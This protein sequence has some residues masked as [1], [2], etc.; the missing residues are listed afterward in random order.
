MEFPF[1]ND[2][3]DSQREAVVYT[4]G[5]SLV[6]AGAGSGKTRV[7]TYKVAW[8]LHQGMHPASILALTF[9]NKAAREMKTRIGQMVG[10]D[11]ARY[12]WMGTFHSLFARILR[13][14]AERIGYTHHFT[15]YDTADSKSLVKAI[16]K[17]MQLDD[18]VYKPGVVLGRISSAKNSLVTPQAYAADSG[19]QQSDRLAKVPMM[20]EIYTTYCAR[21]KQADAMDFDD[22]LLQTNL[23]F[24]DHPDV[25]QKYQS[26]F[27]YILVDEYQD[28]NFAQYLIVKKLAER[29]E[30]ICVVGD[31]AQSIYSFRGAN[32]DNILTFKN[33]YPSARLFK[34]E[35]NYRSTQYILNAANSLIE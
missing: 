6:I 20:K 26:L 31:D 17:E 29:H 11:T 5:P 25:L 4:G 7:L 15:I 21:C 14:E 35:Q 22:L 13:T 34:I 24:R 9:T 12:L 2:L 1:L 28:T 32:I 33:T 19:L 27:Q 16:V 30:K 3:N 8:L 23:L 18:K 10:Y